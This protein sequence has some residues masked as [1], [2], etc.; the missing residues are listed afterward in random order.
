MKKIHWTNTQRHA[1]FAAMLPILQRERPDALANATTTK[2]CNAREYL[3]EAE[4]VA[5]IPQDRRRSTAGSAVA[6]ILGSGWLARLR[7]LHKKHARRQERQRIA[8]STLPPIP[9]QPVAR[10]EQ[11]GAGQLDLLKLEQRILALEIK[12]AQAGL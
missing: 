4:R 11:N 2:V 10:A 12:L 8:P 6:D 3:V 7:V 1:V 5:G 9:V